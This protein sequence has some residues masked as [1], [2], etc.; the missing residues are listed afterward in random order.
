MIEKIKR[1]KDDFVRERNLVIMNLLMGTGIREIGLAGLD[2]PDVY[3]D[4]ETP[5]IKVLEKG[6]IRE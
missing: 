3:L 2:L 4:E 6:D 1:K 5:Y